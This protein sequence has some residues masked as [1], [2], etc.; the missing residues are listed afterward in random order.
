MRESGTSPPTPNDG[1]HAERTP[2]FRD[3]QKQLRE[4]EIVATAAALLSSKG[5]AGMTLDD[6]ANEV[7]I[8]KPTLY[9]HFSSKE[10]LAARIL[11]DALRK[12]QSQ[13]ERLAT[14]LP[15][16]EAV[17]AMI[18]WG[19]GSHFGSGHYADLKGA[20]FLFANPG[21]RKAERDLTD[22]LTAV[23][24]RGQADGTI[25]QAVP[26]RM[27]A[28]T[29]SSILKNTAYEDDHRNGALNIDEL[30]VWTVR[31]LIGEADQASISK[32]RKLR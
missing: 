6:V 27:I 5:Y 23:V 24:E 8:S 14:E 30:K 2:S 10:D 21:V 17:E 12:A 1:A 22:S 28:Q 32:R 4:S 31:L 29:F 15:P 16:R 9:Q 11:L 7:G 3:R 13:L 20:L 25:P 19:I 26:A 18:K